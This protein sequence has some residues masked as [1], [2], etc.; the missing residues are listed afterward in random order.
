MLLGFPSVSAC[1]RPI[2]ALTLEWVE[3]FWPNCTR[4]FHTT[5]R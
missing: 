4:I 5:V 3:G 2:S 1:V